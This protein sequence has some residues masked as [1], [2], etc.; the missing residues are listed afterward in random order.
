M[1]GAQG[2]FGFA[3]A[4]TT[5]TTS[6]PLAVV[7]E[8]GEGLRIRLQYSQELFERQTA[9]GMLDHLLNLV[10]DLLAGTPDR[11][12]KE[13][14]M[15]DEPER[16]RVLKAF[17]DTGMELPEER[18]LDVLFSRTAARH[19]RRPAIV[20]R[21]EE[22]SYA[23]LESRTN[24]LARALMRR[25]V[26]SG[27]RVGILLPRSPEYIMAQ[28][29][30]LKAGGAF[31]P[32][33]PHYPYERIRLMLE[34][35][36][37][38]VLLSVRGMDAPAQDIEVL[39]LDEPD[40]DIWQEDAAPLEPGSG[41]DSLAY[42]IYT[43]GS[44]GRPK[45][46]QIGH[47]N[48]SNMCLWHVR[49]F[50]VDPE[51]RASHLA[52][53]AFDASIWEIWPYLLTGACVVPL[54]SGLDEMT[55]E[56]LAD[57]MRENAITR[58]FVPTK[59][60]EVF[61]AQHHDGLA[62]KTFFTGGDR[63]SAV[64][65]RHDFM[66]MNCYGPTETTV[67]VTAG[68][69][70]AWDNACGS[71]P[72]GGPIGNVQ[73]YILD[74]F[75]RPVPVGVVG[76]IHVGG[77][78]VGS[79][80]L[81]QSEK[82]AEVF[83]PDPFTPGGGR[84]MYATGDLAR[85]NPDGSIAFLGRQDFQVE[86]RGY[87]V[88]I[89]EIEAVLCAYAAIDECVVLG[90]RDA[91]G[92]VRLVAF[93]VAATQVVEGQLRAYLSESL[94]NYMIPAAFIHLDIFPMTANGKLDR[95]ALCE[96]LSTHSEAAP[97]F[98]APAE[99]A[100]LL[101]ASIWQDVLGVPQ[102]GI[103]DN[104]FD[105]GGDSIISLQ[106]VGRLKKQGL[107]IRP[108]DIFEHQTISELA[109]VVNLRRG[110]TAPQ[111]AV[112]GQAPLT[113]IQRWFF[114]LGLSNL[115]HF[116][117]T[118]VFRCAVPLE[119]GTLRE[120]LLAVI[121]H[122]DAL[123]LRFGPDSQECLAPEGAVMFDA[124]TV[125]SHSELEECLD[126]LQRGLDI[127]QGRVFSAGL[128]SL[129]S[130][131]YL[132]LTG[133]HLV[134]DGVSWRII[135][136]DLLNVYVALKG[137][138]DVALPPKT[139]SFKQWAEDLVRYAQSTEVQGEARWWKELLSRPA[140]RIPVELDEGANDMA[141]HALVRVSLETG[142]T[143]DLLREAHTAYHTEV[144]DLLLTALARALSSWT[145]EPC[146]QFDLEGH[147]REEI[148]EHLDVS[149]TVGWFTSLYPVVI[150]LGG[151]MDLDEQIRQVKETRAS[152]PF[153]GVHYGM[154]RY[155]SG[156]EVVPVSHGEV[157]FNYLGQ[158]GEAGLEGSFELTDEL[159]FAPADEGNCRTHLIDINCKVEKGQLHIDVGF[160]RNRHHRA[161][162]E[163]FAHNLKGELL[164]VISRCITTEREG[165]T[166]SDFKLTDISQDQ[167]DDLID[168]VENL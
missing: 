112:T 51:D 126:A 58:S 14:E 84:R 38:R 68:D 137:G 148:M 13:L 5:E 138:Q 128:Y 98:V 4:P 160:S 35:C 42:V 146:V 50:A 107:E 153:K 154:L 104:F 87:R 80:Y 103:H 55:P 89:G 124:K 151:R 158:I 57:W 90:S 19:A 29:A 141:S 94:P 159:N 23:E 119:T 22:L 100:E 150:D 83:L 44:T 64:P 85:W 77:A 118:L 110:V 17:N 152:I 69:V 3:D 32:I 131:S 134:V 96:M 75:L 91:Q 18:R 71:P 39:A 105:L 166:P 99:E 37:A 117:Q 82:T 156:S 9:G 164:A 7:V 149:R 147:G 155:L 121:N 24:R 20:F 88:E 162:I 129:G 161:T 46:V 2:D 145:H 97:E 16:Q 15:L 139:T 144:S 66:V 122:H 54:E 26:A 21:G 43:S 81:G 34:D 101:I 6:F 120:S 142:P 102:V 72:I 135:M 48:V 108:R 127:G 106:V 49:R 59:F 60:A 31:V 93:Y 73:I 157:L 61:L 123:R 25:G 67:L 76:Q 165:Y 115:N 95:N 140:G 63:L 52:G 113:P 27:V 28:L 136:E 12:L 41:A 62:L 65:G 109:G 40:S 33:D 125:A 143:G 133:H 74:P 114:E 116:N 111:G 53:V 168:D 86:I 92:A 45:G 167:L 163:E 11:S 1:R 78:Q 8:P 130:A 10:R 36:G 30:V 79:G 70:S 56:D 132:V 47:G